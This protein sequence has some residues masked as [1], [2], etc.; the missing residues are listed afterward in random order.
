MK[1]SPGPLAAFGAEKRAFEKNIHEPRDAFAANFGRL[2]LRRIQKKLAARSDAQLLEDLSLSWMSLERRSKILRNRKLA[3]FAV[4]AEFNSCYF[5]DVRAR[6]LAQRGVELETIA[7]A[8]RRHQGGARAASVHDGKD[9]NMLLLARLL[10]EPAADVFRPVPVTKH[11][12]FVDGGEEAAGLFCGGHGFSEFAWRKS[13]LRRNRS[14]AR[15]FA[16]LH[17]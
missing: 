9:G 6:G 11:P 4:D 12:D 13:A 3:R 14:R 5:A 2:C 10:L 17:R 8:T 7:A 15:V 16:S 1:Q